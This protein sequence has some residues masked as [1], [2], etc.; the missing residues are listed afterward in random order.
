MCPHTSCAADALLSNLSDNKTIGVIISTA[1]YIKF[2][3]IVEKALGK[4]TEIPLSIQNLLNKQKN[5]IPISGDYIE[6]KNKFM[7]QNK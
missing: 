6:F 3:N 5:K 7:G 2:N 1:H 4:E